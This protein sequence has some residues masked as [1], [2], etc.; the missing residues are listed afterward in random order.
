MKFISLVATIEAGHK[1]DLIPPSTTSFP[2]LLSDNDSITLTWNTSSIFPQ[3]NP[4]A[5]PPNLDIILYKFDTSSAQWEEHNL[6]VSRM[7]NDGSEQLS[8]PVG[9]SDD[10][11]PIVIH[12]ATTLDPNTDFG[13]DNDLYR[14]IFRMQ[15]RVGVW[16]SEYYYINPRL[17]TSEGRDMCMEWYNAQP[18][19]LPSS[20]TSGS[21]ACA[22]TEDRARLPTSGLQEVDLVSLSGNTAYREHWLRTFHPRVEKCYKEAR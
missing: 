21:L 9:V 18:V 7:V 11:T 17:A 8:I 1:A 6:L 16:T 10:I 3:V 20:L 5:A 4:E 14:E 12:I 2:L 13:E 15:Q 19:D 22:P